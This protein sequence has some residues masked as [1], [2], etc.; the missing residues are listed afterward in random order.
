MPGPGADGIPTVVDFK[1]DALGSARPAD[2]AERYRAQREVY[3]LAAGPAGA[4]VIHVFLEAADEPVVAEMGPDD[5][6]AARARLEA[7]I[8]RMRGGEFEVA[9]EPYPALCIGCP[10]AARLCPRP[11]WRPS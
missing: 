11:A 4:R 5:L 2:L 8:A 10:A 6:A 9:A 7:M 1:T 3:A